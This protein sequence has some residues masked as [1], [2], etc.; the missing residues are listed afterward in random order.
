MGRVTP[1][2]SPVPGRPGVEA[3]ALQERIEIVGSR[4]VLDGQHGAHRDIVVLNAGAGN[5]I[6][7]GGSGDP[8]I[9]ISLS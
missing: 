7:Y 1:A 9:G 4:R 6:I 5:D 8:T 2:R 3:R